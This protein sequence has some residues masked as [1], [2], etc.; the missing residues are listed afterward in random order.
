MVASPRGI[1]IQSNGAVKRI[2]NF[3][4]A[5]KKRNC[6][7]ARFAA[8]THFI[9][10]SAFS[11]SLPFN[12]SNT[13]PP[14]PYGRGRSWEVVRT[15]KGLKALAH[16]RKFPDD[17]V[18]VFAFRKPPAAVERELLTRFGA[19]HPDLDKLIHTTQI[20]HSDSIGI[21]VKVVQ[22]RRKASKFR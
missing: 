16:R 12:V 6:C 21:S 1:V 5:K 3:S 10:L 9:L 4:W 17:L 13:P 8:I 22:G 2:E 19:L 15:W 14:L 20:S 7:Y 11:F 18:I